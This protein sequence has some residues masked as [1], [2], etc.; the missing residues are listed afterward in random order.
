MLGL[1]SSQFDP[2]RTLDLIGASRIL[3]SWRR[4]CGHNFLIVR[5]MTPRFKVTVAWPQQTPFQWN[6]RLLARVSTRG[7]PLGKSRGIAMKKLILTGA[8]LA[9]LLGG[10]AMA[11]DLPAAPIYKA[12]PPVAVWSWSGFYIGLNGG[13][14]FGSD[15]F[16]QSLTQPG[17]V[18]N[19]FDKHTVAPRGGLFGG[20]AGYN[21]QVGSVVLGV[22]GDAQWAD[23]RGTS[24]GLLC[25]NQTGQTAGITVTQKLKWFSTVRGR[26]GWAHDSY[27]LYVTGGGA[28]A[29]IEEN[30]AL[31]VSGGGGGT[32][33]ASSSTTKSGWTAGAGIEAQLWGNWTGK[34]E[35]LHMDLGNMT[36]V[37]VPAPAAGITIL[38]TSHI[39]DDLIRAGLNYKFGYGLTLAKY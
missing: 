5:K 15:D 39:R 33:G 30:D 34:L 28:W 21:W 20:Q 16:T 25:L 1:S 10:S 13:Y 17:I 14:S 12:P 22:E 18:A 38:T 19:S 36:T 35:Y 26:L 37:F 11:A 24:C 7:E 3:R 2:N 8:A 27:L 6:G 32:F 29:G 4:S 9:A 23:Q 31:V